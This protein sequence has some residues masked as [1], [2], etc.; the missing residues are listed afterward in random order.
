MNINKSSVVSPSLESSPVLLLRVFTKSQ[1]GMSELSSL[2]ECW[3]LVQS[4]KLE[5]I[6]YYALKKVENQ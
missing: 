2:G 1:V 4:D 6:D 3:E 5:I